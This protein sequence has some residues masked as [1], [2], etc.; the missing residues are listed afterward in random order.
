[1]Q[2][3]NESKINPDGNNKITQSS[4]TGVKP[5][6]VQWV[7][8]VFLGM[9]IIMLTG[10]AMR[11]QMKLKRDKLGE[12]PPIYGQVPAFTFTDDSQTSFGLE[13]LKGRIW[14]VDFVFTRCGYP[15]PAITQN[16]S[17]LQS[18][19]D[20]NEMGN[21]KLVTVS[22]DPEYDTPDVLKAYGK[23]YKADFDRWSFLTGDKKAIYDFI[24][25]GFDLM[26][27][28]N[29]EGT[30]ISEMFVHSDKMVLIDRDEN[31]RGYYGG[32]DD[33][34]LKKLR[35]DLIK[36]SRIREPEPKRIEKK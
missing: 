9:F 23:K 3:E 31:I 21:V 32:I 34:D 18:W 4:D 30:P 5:S 27:E 10:M 11:E 28:Q 6:V 2:T 25:D 1:M 8:W 35:L 29:P 14:V 20:E 24:L 12:G 33:D 16:M 15:C 19:L 7:G 22:V 13:Q 36:V 17:E 26:V